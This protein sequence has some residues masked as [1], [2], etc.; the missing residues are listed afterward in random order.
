MAT[1]NIP[2]QGFTASYLQIRIAHQH[3]T[4]EYLTAAYRLIDHYGRARVVRTIL[5]VP[6]DPS[7]TDDQLLTSITDY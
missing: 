7:L 3:L 2:R 1:T 6:N 5:A 4:G